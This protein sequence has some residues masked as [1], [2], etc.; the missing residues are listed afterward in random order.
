[1]SPTPPVALPPVTA[2]YT[3][4]LQKAS[5]QVPAAQSLYRFSRSADG[6]TRVDTGNM[7]TISNPASGQTI[8]LDHLKKTATIQ[9]NAP[10]APPNPVMPQMPGFSPP[11]MPAAP[12]APGV[13]VEDLGKT[14]LQGQEV[15]G[16]RFV[17]PPFAPPKPPGV[18]VPG[19]PQMPQIPGMP[20]A[21]PKLPQI[22]G[23]PGVP[24]L[25]QIP[26]MPAAPQAPQ[27]PGMPAA[28]P[29]APQIPGMPAAP[30]A[31]QIPG[32]P[33]A[34]QAPQMPG[35]P[36]APATPR[37]PATAEVWTSTSMAVPMLSKVTGSFGQL[38]QVCRSAVPGEPHPSAFQIPPGYKLIAPTPKVG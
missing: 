38:T 37:P 15:E 5:T 14:V 10:P 12:Q 9:P 4:T 19:A 7:S 23:M 20:A 17:I 28:A 11:G 27:I 1:M 26:G 30:Q 31:P 3:S 16:K 24:K 18:Q 34:P 36:A 35:M 2:E 13:K 6:K 22:P 29:K 25:P 21:A 8:V 33:A 32:M